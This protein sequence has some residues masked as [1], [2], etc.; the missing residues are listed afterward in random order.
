MQGSRRSDQLGT[1]LRRPMPS[2]RSSVINVRQKFV[3]T[4][5]FPIYQ[6][7]SAVAFILMQKF[8]YNT[9]F[10]CKHHG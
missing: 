6:M 2:S 10:F 5:N 9:T 3:Q 8:Y 4:A 7:P 1:V